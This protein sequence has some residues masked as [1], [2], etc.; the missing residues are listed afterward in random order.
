M[1]PLISFH[2]LNPSNACSCQIFN[3]LP[4]C[5]P[6]PT[7]W[8][9]PW[10]IPSNSSPE[11]ITILPPFSHGQTTSILFSASVLN[12]FLQPLSLYTC[13][14]NISLLTLN[15]LMR[16]QP[17]SFFTYPSHL[18]LLTQSLY[19][20]HSSLKSWQQWGSTDWCVGCNVQHQKAQCSHRGPRQHRSCCCRLH[21]LGVCGE[22]SWPAS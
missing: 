20:P 13:L 2:S 19:S 9:L 7:Q 22:Y 15:I 17:P 18:N 5:L 12:K 11:C 10:H 21:S 3:T 14:S 16:H 4:P 6:Q 8:V 1:L